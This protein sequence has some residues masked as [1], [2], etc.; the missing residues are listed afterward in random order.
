MGTVQ[1]LLLAATLTAF[2]F[3]L[4]FVLVKPHRPLVLL[5]ALFALLCACLLAAI[6]LVGVMFAAVGVGD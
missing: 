6:V 1:I 3:V 4:V 2:A 5:S